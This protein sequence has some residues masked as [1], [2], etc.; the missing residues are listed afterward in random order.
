MLRFT[1]CWEQLTFIMMNQCCIL[2]LDTTTLAHGEGLT[3][4]FSCG[5]G[6]CVGSPLV[7]YVFDTCNLNIYELERGKAVFCA[8]LLDLFLVS[9]ILVH[10]MSKTGLVS[11]YKTLIY[12]LSLPWIMIDGVTGSLTVFGAFAL[13]T[14]SVAGA[15]WCPFLWACW[16]EWKQ[17]YYLSD[18]SLESV[19][20]QKT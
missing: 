12:C 10:L 5:F 1:V 20:I 15:V 11:H 9:F 8:T 3:G 7:Q 6:S 18:V 17:I 13:V 14:F 19:H 16:N 4:F 2:K